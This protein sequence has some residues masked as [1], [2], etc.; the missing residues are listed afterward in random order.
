MASAC[1]KIDDRLWR[2]QNETGDMAV[3]FNDRIAEFNDTLRDDAL[4]SRDVVA[5][6]Q[7]V[8]AHGNGTVAELVRASNQRTQNA[9]ASAVAFGGIT[10]RVHG[11]ESTAVAHLTTSV[12]I[13]QANVDSL[14]ASV[15]ALVALSTTAPPQ[16]AV[17]APT[18]SA[19][20]A[21]SAPPATPALMDDDSEQTRMLFAQF[22]AANG[23]R[24]READVDDT[25]RNTRPRTSEPAQPV[26]PVLVNPPPIVYTPVCQPPTS[27][28]LPT[29]AA[30]GAA[31][32]HAPVA[33]PLPA[34]AAAP[35]PVAVSTPTP[36]HSVSASGPYPNLSI[37]FGSFGISSNILQTRSR[38]PR[39]QMH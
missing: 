1:A 39:R 38:L 20:P 28:A 22:L 33:A 11:I 30:T 25:L 2:L 35:A 13:L 16:T 32:V 4:T 26:Q 29:L 3:F 7:R 24:A 27:G 18:A 6:A 5:I 37:I 15:E 23:K 17:V 21:P 14:R 34:L 10:S 31:A 36:A 9:A 19:A 8:D 12:G